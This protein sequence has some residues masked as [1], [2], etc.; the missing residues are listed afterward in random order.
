MTQKR[1]IS[2]VNQRAPVPD[3]GDRAVAQ[4][5]CLPGVRCDPRS[6]IYR[7]G[8][9]TVGGAGQMPIDRLKHAAQS[10]SALQSE[11]CVGN[12]WAIPQ[13]LQKLC[14][15]RDPVGRTFIQRNEGCKRNP[16]ARAV[17][18]EQP[19][20]RRAEADPCTQTLRVMARAVI[21]QFRQ[22]RRLLLNKWCSCRQDDGARVRFRLPIDDRLQ[23]ILLRIDRKIAAPMTGARSASVH[24]G[25]LSF[26]GR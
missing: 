23:S 7:I 18:H 8:D 11:A 13:N 16:W 12:G 17:D 4:C 20:R 5:G 6:A 9:V 21:V 26:G 3:Q 1:A 24:G 2:A 25:H 15:R 10:A 22:W 14:E 19:D